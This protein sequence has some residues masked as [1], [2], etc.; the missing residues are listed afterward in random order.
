VESRNGVKTGL[1]QQLTG[2]RAEFSMEN[3]AFNFISVLSFFLIICYLIYDAYLGQTLLTVMLVLLLPVLGICYYFSRFKKKYE[4]G[5]IIYAL[6]S[7]A[8]LILNYFYNSGING[9]TLMIFL[10]TLAFFSA[11][12][13]KRLFI[14][15]ILLHGI[16]G[17]GLLCI[18]FMH[19]D[20]VPNTYPARKSRFI[21]M[22]FTYGTAVFFIYAII[23]YIR[24]YF[25]KERLRSEERAAALVQQNEERQK[26]NQLLEQ[27]NQEKN[28]LFSIVSHDLKTPLDAVLG[29]LE[30]L[31]KGALDREEKADIETE[32]LEQTK[33]TSDLLQNLLSWAKAQMHGITVNLVSVDLKD[34]MISTTN[35]RLGSAARKGI[36]ITNSIREHIEVVADKDMLNI[37]LRNLL[38]NA[39]KFTRPGGEITIRASIKDGT[40][41]VSVEDTGIGIPTDRQEDIFTAHTRS[42]FGTNN[43]KGIGLGLH[44]CKEFMEYQH[45]RIWFESTLGKGSVFFIALPRTRL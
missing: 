2:D 19:P 35:H 39:I 23:N 37:V 17:I 4:P 30:I 24:N 38:N 9:P 1:W 20:M 5:L 3:R 28:K 12:S 33:Y 29:Y 34:V 26:Q 31:S 25:N 27:V 18:E 16:L 43:E 6:F 11:I 42:T 22:G 8:A 41:V 15:L 45:G 7:Y 36:K 32:L 40:A 10:I 14:T 44:M 21:D 13:R